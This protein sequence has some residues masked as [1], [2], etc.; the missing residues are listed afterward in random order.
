MESLQEETVFDF[1]H[2]P[3][4]GKTTRAA[5]VPGAALKASSVNRGAEK[6]N[7]AFFTAGCLV[8][9]LGFSFLG[10]L[11]ARFVYYLAEDFP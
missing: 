11:L 7:F 2:K 4:L 1:K 8:L 6:R 3:Q 10:R 9:A 5:A